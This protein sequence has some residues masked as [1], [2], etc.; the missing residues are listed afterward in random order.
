[1][2]YFLQVYV[3]N[4]MARD[5]NGKR[6]TM[7]QISESTMQKEI[8]FRNRNIWTIC[9]QYYSALSIDQRLKKDIYKGI[10]KSNKGQINHR[11]TE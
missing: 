4:P 5:K 11:L 9:K 6:I 3:C 1:M 7:K 10:S 2:V 8:T